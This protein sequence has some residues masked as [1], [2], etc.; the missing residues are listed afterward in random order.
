MPYRTFLFFPPLIDCFLSLP[1]FSFLSSP[2]CAAGPFV[3]GF[4]VIPY[5]DLAALEAKLD[6]DKNIVA[7]MV[8]PIQGEAGVVVPDAGYL[9]KAQQLLHKHNA[10]LIADE[11][12][13]CV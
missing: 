5:N 3:P 13:A 1:A 7:F 4:E 8:E 9:K 11:V 6:A 10:L 2:P 12:R